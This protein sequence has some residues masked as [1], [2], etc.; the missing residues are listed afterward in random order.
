VA[1]ALQKRG[2]MPRLVLCGKDIEREALPQCRVPCTTVP[3]LP[4]GGPIPRRIVAGMTDLAGLLRSLPLVRRADA[5]VGMGG[6]GSAAPVLAAVLQRRPLLLHEANAVP[7]R[8]TELFARWADAVA[9]G[10]PE[11]TAFLSVRNPAVVCTGVA[12]RPELVAAAAAAA[13]RR[14]D[15][16]VILVL[17]GSRGAQVLNDALPPALEILRRQGRR[18]SVEHVS[19]PGRAGPVAAA[20]RR[21]GI[22]ARVHE[23]I[24]DM[25]GL[26]RRVTVAVA[27]AGASTCAELALF[28]I[29]AVLI[30]Y[31][32]AVRD[33]QWKNAA[34]LAAAG[35]AIA[36]PE[37]KASPAVI[38]ESLE[39]LLADET[40]YREAAQA[41]RSRA[42]PD[43]AEKMV[44]LVETV[45]AKRHRGR[46]AGD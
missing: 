32:H 39:R 22:P 29:P 4:L 40:F 45:L 17:G 7:G 30:P 23:F 6:Y 25:A 5:V 27:R 19:G 42:R 18:F 46:A 28:G 33:H 20:Y 12:V 2:H 14:S 21:A 36:C 43:A 10:F 1:L 41:M 38:A 9:L 11:C 15:P 8:V 37:P 44:D 16:P 35:A 34:A 13:P 24:R 26:Y 31:P 3:M